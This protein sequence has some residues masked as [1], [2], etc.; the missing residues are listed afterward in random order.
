MVLACDTPSCHDDHWCQLILNSH[1]AGQSYGQACVNTAN[2][3][4]SH[5][6]CDLDLQASD[7]VLECDISSCHDD[8]LYQL[9]LKSDHKLDT[10]MCHFSL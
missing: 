9:T 2:A 8:H 5:I 1:P 3:Q 10:S 7:I 6:P 4:R